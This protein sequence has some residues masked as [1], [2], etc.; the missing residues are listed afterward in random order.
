[1]TKATYKGLLLANRAKVMWSSD[2]MQKGR[3]NTMSHE[4]AVKWSIGE[5]QNKKRRRSRQA[6]VFTTG[7]QA[8]DKINSLMEQGI[9]I[10]DISALIFDADDIHAEPIELQAKHIIQRQLGDNSTGIYRYGHVVDNNLVLYDDDYTPVADDA[11]IVSISIAVDSEGNATKAHASVIGDT[12]IHR[13][14][15]YRQSTD[16]AMALLLGTTD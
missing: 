14:V 12:A 6:G 11:P 4:F 8:I 13:E 15:A 1:M 3:N 9:S 10:A 5:K 2:S 16:R 7:Q